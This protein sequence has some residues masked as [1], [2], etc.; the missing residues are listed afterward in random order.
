MLDTSH[1]R[2][3]VPFLEPVGLVDALVAEPEPGAAPRV[4]VDARQCADV[5]VVLEGNT[6]GAGDPPVGAVLVE[7]AALHPAEQ[8]PEG[9]DVQGLGGV[10]VPP[11]DRARQDLGEFFEDGDPARCELNPA[12]GSRGCGS[13]LGGMRC[14]YERAPT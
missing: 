2:G 4:G 10:D 11:A 5:V 14:R 13:S 9:D 8:W 1:R 7:I 12:A 6:A 3:G